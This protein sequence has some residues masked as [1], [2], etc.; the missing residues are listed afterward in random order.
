M[1]AKKWTLPFSFFPVGAA[2]P[3]VELSELQEAAICI[4]DEI[5][6]VAFGQPVPPASL[7]PQEFSLP[8]GA[9]QL[10]AGGR[11]PKGRRKAA[12][13]PSAAPVVKVR[14]PL[15][16]PLVFLFALSRARTL[17]ARTSVDG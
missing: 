8:G 2:G 11:L 4:T 6:L 7:H 17:R 3:A 14:A 15:K 12:V 5:P 13:S 9:F 10:K 16:R 1:V